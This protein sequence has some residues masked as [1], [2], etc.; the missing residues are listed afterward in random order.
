MEATLTKTNYDLSQYGIKDANVNW[1][2]T[3]EQLQAKTVE[4][5]LGTETENGTL[6]KIQ[7]TSPAVRLKIDS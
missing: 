5:G 2:W 1:N 6:V 7:E 3:P 4:L